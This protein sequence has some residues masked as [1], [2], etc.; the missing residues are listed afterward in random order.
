M[1]CKTSWRND[2][3]RVLFVLAALVVPACVAYTV[4]FQWHTPMLDIALERPLSDPGLSVVK[5]VKPGGKSEAAGLWNLDILLTVDGQAFDSW[6]DLHLESTCSIEFLRPMSWKSCQPD[7]VNSTLILTQHG[8][9]L[10]TFYNGSKPICTL[11]L[12][13]DVQLWVLTIP[14]LRAAQVNGWHLFSAVVVA[15]IF[16]G[17]GLLLS[18]RRFHRVEVRL[19]FLLSQTMALVLLVVLA[20][21]YHWPI[22]AWMLYLSIVGFHTAAPLFFHYHI[23]FPVVLGSARQRRWILGL[24]YGLAAGAMAGGLSRMSHWMALAALYTFSVAMLGV[25]IIFYVYFRRATPDGRRRLRL[26]VFGTALGLTPPALVYALPSILHNSAT[27][28]PMPEWLVGLFLIIPPLSYLYAT[29][30]HNL[31]DMDRLLNRASVY[32][33]L[34]LGVFFVCFGP[35]LLLYRHLSDDWLLQTAA[36]TGMALVVA[37]VFN[38]LR[39]RVQRL[40]DRLFYGGWYDYPG[41]VETISNALSSSLDWEQL[42][43]V[44]TCQVPNLMQL[45]PGRFQIGEFDTILTQRSHSP[46]LLFPLNFQDRVAGLWIVEGRRDGEDFSTVDRRIL[47]TLARQ[48]EIALNNVLLIETLRRQLDETR[49]MQRQLLRSREEERKH[50]ARELHDGPI[51]SLVGLNLQLGLL[52][53]P[54][55]SNFSKEKNPAQQ[56]PLTDIRAEIRDLLADLRQVCADLRPPMLDVL[57]LG[58]ALRAL[59]QDWSKQHNVQI[60]LDLPPDAALRSLPGEVSVHF[61]RM[62]QEALTNIAHHAAAHQARIRLNWQNSQLALTIQDDGQGFVVP[63]VLQ[64]LAAQGCYGLVGMR[65]RSDLIG[66][67]WALESTPGQGTT[68]HIVWQSSLENDLW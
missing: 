8:S 45:Y 36:F 44:L 28:T 26:V 31:F 21:P 29:A 49:Q 14:V 20:F 51:Q 64:D 38:P 66:A 30:R 33:I 46:Q 63:A 2:F 61:Y 58:S 22:P 3:S 10:T 35:F 56:E 37:S 25:G 32:F 19:L 34:S 50:L 7:V 52:L 17:T 62:V 4:Y 23:T 57:G 53:S 42:I 60:R 48:A 39:I 68:L 1:S 59:T 27:F 47:Q 9:P 67:Q 43:S 5:T 6:L 15:L 18:R 12:G 11:E 16:W 24:L 41:V 55:E 13:Q 54:L 65:E 40:V